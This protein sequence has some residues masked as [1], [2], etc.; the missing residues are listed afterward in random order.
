[1]EKCLKKHHPNKIEG[2]YFVLFDP[3]P[4][5]QK[6]GVG[7]KE[8]RNKF[9]GYS[10]DLSQGEINKNETQSNQNRR[11]IRKNQSESK[12]ISGFKLGSFLAASNYP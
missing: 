8:A 11:V 9:L 6:L 12:T 7:A 1:M 10:Q 5:L 2:G 4:P 3:F